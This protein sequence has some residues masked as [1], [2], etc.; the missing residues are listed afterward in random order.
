MD[1][2]FVSG[3]LVFL[4]NSLNTWFAKKQSI[5]SCSSTEAE[6]RALASSVIELCWIRML[7]KDFGVFLPHPPILW[8]DNV[9][10]PAIF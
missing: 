6:Y 8:C 7:L 5:V 4:G 2:K 9:S 1:R 10:A 3:I